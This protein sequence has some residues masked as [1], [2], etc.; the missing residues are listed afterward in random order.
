MSISCYVYYRVSETRV[1][2]ASRAA[3]RLATLMRDATGIRPRLMKK[4]EDPLLWMEVYEGISEVDAFTSS[5]RDCLGQTGLEQ[6]LADDSS[7]R[8]ELFECA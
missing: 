4:I 2:E 3:Q 5:L 8:I 7:R 1:A 6:L